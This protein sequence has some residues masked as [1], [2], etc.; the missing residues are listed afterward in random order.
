MTT[1]SDEV[2]DENK[3]LVVVGS[4]AGGVGALSTLVSTLHK[5]FPAPI[6]L[7]Q[8]LDPQRPSHLGPI[9]ER[10]STLPIVVVDEDAPTPLEKGKIYVV[11]SNRHVK[12]VDGHVNLEKDSNDRPKPSVDL[13]LSSAAKSYGEHLIAV[14]LTGSGSDGAA[15]AVDVKNAGGV[16][17][18]QNPQTAPYPS[19]PLSLPPTAVDHVMEM[20]QIGP[21]LYDLLKGVEL[22]LTEKADDPLR[23]LLAQVGAETNID[24]R[25]YKSST[26]LRRIGRRLAV[27]HTGS[28]REYTDYLRTH[29]AEI[30]ELVKAFLIKVTG[31][32]RDPEAFAAL[33]DTII[34]I[35]IEQGRA[36]G[37]TI[38]LW[39]AG[40]ATGEEPYSLALL[41]ADQLDGEFPEWNIKIFATDLA[42]DSLAFARR[43]LYP[44]N[45]LKD[46][47]DDY[48]VRFFE[49][50]EHGYRVNKALRQTV[51]FGHQD[52]SKGVP[53]PRI[54]LVTCRNLLI[55]LKPDLQQTVLDLFA[56]S[57][58]QTKGYLFLGKAETTRPT[59]ATFE[60]INKK[61]K[62]YRCLSGPVTL[63]LQESALTVASPSG[64]N[65]FRRR[66]LTSLPGPTD[67]TST[68]SDFTHLRRLN[69]TLLRSTPVAIIVI[70]RSYRIVTINA[71]ARRLLGVRELAHDHDFLHTV[72]G[73]PYQEVR[74]AI[75]AV[76]REHSTVA[77][78]ELELDPSADGSGR[79]VNFLIT[80]MQVEQGSSELAVITAMD[81]TDQIQV[82][83]RLEVVQREHGDLV[84]ELSTINKRLG[85]VNKELQDANEEL[86]AANE[87]LMLTQEELQATNEEFEATN[88]ELQATNEELETNN[89]ELQATNEELQTTN[90]ELTARTS[91]L[92]EVSQQHRI[93]QF[94]LSSV[95]E[96]FPHYAMVLNAEDLSIHAVNSAY[97]E[98][99]GTRDIIG[100]ALTDVF[101]GNDMEQFVEILKS[102]VKTAKAINTPPFVASVG[103]SDNNSR[104]F[105]H[106]IIPISDSSGA[107]INRLFVYSEGVEALT[108]DRR[109][110][111][112]NIV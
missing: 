30:Q 68:E 97:Q 84:N 32:F 31:F 83:R 101:G 42:A 105:V 107:A 8:H 67:I 24:F 35:L 98:L 73:L 108:G 33:K 89:E 43:G 102:S 99:L 80:R 72:R 5:S 111:A 70:D 34:P 86:Q 58:S 29:P 25:N 62:I 103:G 6:V 36:N 39:S 109:K 63:P 96:R 48:R 17:I 78:P 85:T 71:S 13:L 95:L 66:P 21:L 100:L 65:E 64:W 47:P 75:D 93:E 1:E 44:E 60:L 90:D 110:S 46:L 41:L 27:T 79:Y 88:E 18:I 11:P 37:R 53:F 2:K 7:A 61:W 10:R 16:V 112:P 94:E 69:D 12:I 22:R 49:K 9:L 26:I 56:Y 59:K 14:I 51:I 52:I 104:R 91:E 3:D 15:G 19:M 45:V 92:Q 82:R 87:E 38:R 40:C 106:T 28:I 23:D 57:L 54:D 74:R 20:E 77:L 50:L 81:A 4:S 76:F 55:Y